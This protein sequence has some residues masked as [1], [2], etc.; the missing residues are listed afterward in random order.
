MTHSNPVP[1]VLLRFYWQLWRICLQS[2]DIEFDTLEPYG[3]IGRDRHK[4][5]TRSAE[6]YQK[7]TLLRE[8]EELPLQRIPGSNNDG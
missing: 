1:D 3:F 2:S 5:L 7:H 8:D 6:S 4:V